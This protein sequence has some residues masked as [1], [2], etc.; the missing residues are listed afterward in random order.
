MH[1][2]D[3]F[4]RDAVGWS[5]SSLAKR[6]AYCGIP[7]YGKREGGLSRPNRIYSTLDMHAVA[8]LWENR[9][10]ACYHSGDLLHW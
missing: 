6:L 1:Y 9:E 5:T 2:L 7:Q 10:G 4:A 3:T 8:F